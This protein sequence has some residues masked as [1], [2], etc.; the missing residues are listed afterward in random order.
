MGFKFTEWKQ[1]NYVIWKILLILYIIWLLTRG[2][3]NEP[4]TFGCTTTLFVGLHRAL[5][6]LTNHFDHCYCDYA[7]LDLI[8][9]CTHIH[10]VYWQGFVHIWQGTFEGHISSTS[11]TSLSYTFWLSISRKPWQTVQA[12][13]LAENRKSHVGF[14]LADLHLTLAHSD[15]Q[16]QGR[17]HLHCEYLK[18]GDT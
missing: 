17:P 8:A 5:P 2:P 1:L 14:P 12:L 6:V 4:R 15:S 9:P 18:T 11:S 3:P 10:T 16:V 7:W 13:L